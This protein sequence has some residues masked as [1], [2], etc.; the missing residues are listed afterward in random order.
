MEENR[1][2]ALVAA[3]GQIG[4]GS[5]REAVQNARDND[6]DRFVRNAAAIALRQL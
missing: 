3:L 4:D 2:K 1:K 5:V 6:P